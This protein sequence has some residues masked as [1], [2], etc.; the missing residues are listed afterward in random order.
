[1][2]KRVILSNKGYPFI[3][4]GQLWMYRNNLISAEEGIEDGD[5]VKIV[6]EDGEY[7]ATGF[8]SAVSHIA[9]RIVSREEKEEINS[10]YFRKQM[11][12][13][14]NYRKEVLKEAWD[15]CRLIY[16]EADGIPGLIVDRYNDV[17]VSQVSCKSIELRKE[18]LYSVLT[19]ILQKNGQI[20]HSVYERND[21]KVREKEGLPLYKGYFCGAKESTETIISENGIKIRVDYEKGQ[22]TG[23]FLD[24]KLNRK[25][26]QDFSK[27][28]RVLDCFS[29]TGGFALNAAKGNAKSVVAVDVSRTALDQGFANA[30]MNQLED[31][32]T[33]VQDD[34][35]H[36][37]DTLK[38]GDFDL[39]ILDP[40]AFTKSR[41][42]IGHAY[43]GYKEI[44]QKAMHVLKRGSYLASCSCSRYMEA[45]LFYQMLLDAA[46]EE[47]VSLKPVTLQY[48][49]PDHPILE[50]MKETEYLK[51][52]VFEIIK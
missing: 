19:E 44:N 49:S 26:V 29:H 11:E 6:S 28:L 41:R 33:F 43:K 16:G 36:Y 18:E 42:T 24:Q 51:F 40:P 15:N 5:I 48:Q 8:Y 46:K 10:D 17:L 50:T 30:C 13:A 35:F 9:V 52:Y 3:K 1:M 37:L 27:G 23:Y 21:I 31:T 32:I 14:C 12:K 45:D 22:K 20:I 39:I 38:E 47:N 4:K 7:L 25:W 34:V 2:L